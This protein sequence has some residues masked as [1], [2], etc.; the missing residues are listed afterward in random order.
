MGLV[1]GSLRQGTLLGLVQQAAALLQLED[2]SA[3]QA[4]LQLQPGH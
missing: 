3:D 4:E 1:A 2:T